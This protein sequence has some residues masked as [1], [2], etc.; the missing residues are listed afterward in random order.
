LR[1][2][3]HQTGKGLGKNVHTAYMKSIFG[4]NE[5]DT[6]DNAYQEPRGTVRQFLEQ[7][8]LPQQ[9]PGGGVTEK[10]DALY[11]AH[12]AMRFGDTGARDRY[13]LKYA[14]LGG[15]D[16][17]LKDSL[18]AMNPVGKLT[19][20]QLSDFGKGLAQDDKVRVRRCL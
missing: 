16:Q 9:P 11:L 10:A 19:K 15:D 5:F 17:G 4:I 20:N 8:G 1:G 14:Q 6:G 12:Q 2:I 18:K 13:L 3:P 7:R